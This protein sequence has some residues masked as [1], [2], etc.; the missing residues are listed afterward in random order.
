MTGRRRRE[1]ERRLSEL[2]TGEVPP[3]PAGL[4][5][6]IRAEIPDGLA[7]PS[8]L[9]E[10]ERSPRPGRRGRGAS[11]GGWRSHRWRIAAAL[12]MTVGAGA[13]LWWL[14][15]G[16]GEL[17][18][19]AE[20]TVSAPAAPRAR[21][22]SEGG[23]GAAASPPVAPGA[24]AT[25]PLATSPQLSPEAPAASA[26]KASRLPT[27]EDSLGARPAAVAVPK[28]QPSARVPEPTTR[29]DRGRAAGEAAAAAEP[30]VERRLGA[31]QATAGGAAEGRAEMPEVPIAEPTG[32]ARVEES[33]EIG[34][35]A[36]STAASRPAGAAAVGGR[37]E[38]RR[39]DERGATAETGP[40]PKAE[41]RKKAAAPAEPELVVVAPE[42]PPRSA[43]IATGTLAAAP[44]GWTEVRRALD[45]DRLP[46]PETVDVDAMV[47]AFATGDPPPGPGVALGLV[48]DGGPPAADAGPQV[49]LLRVHLSAVEPAGGRIEVEIDARQAARVRR[50]GGGAIAPVGSR[51]RDEVPLEL[52]A[53]GDATLLYEIRLRAG[54]DTPGSA[55]RPLA[56]VR[57]GERSRQLR[58][59]D[60]AATW[61]ESSPPF[62]LAA[63]AAAFAEALRAPGPAAAG[64]LAAIVRR[65]G[66][67]A[68]L[69]FPGQDAAAELARLAA[70]A[71]E[72]VRARTTR[73][74]A[75]P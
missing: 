75:P 3:P 11:E 38:E 8:G 60:L 64:R 68:A 12:V 26:P 40:P 37:E 59:A 19:Q 32:P 42:A 15:Q 6:R 18:P 61:E 67:L 24:P 29:S 49:R 58:A 25:G 17:G 4:V 55:L 20:R 69:D 74:P 71:S 21:E 46:A 14:R 52:T 5:E 31:D 65:A 2:G 9:D 22:A 48:A 70:R 72:P 44:G 43:G 41:L 28:P 1:I 39:Q 57:F 63:L 23:A 62:R 16:G 13:A 66:E 34:A 73:R 30:G 35:P 47:T 51:F 50:I 54:A 36:A 45:D 53:N 27:P 10:E 56:T 7:A 33:E